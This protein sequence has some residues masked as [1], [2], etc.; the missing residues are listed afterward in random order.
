M[1]VGKIVVVTVI[2]VIHCE[3][4]CVHGTSLWWRS[5]CSPLGRT[6]CPLSVIHPLKEVRP[7]G[8]V[9]CGF[10]TCNHNKHIQLD[11][12]NFRSYGKPGISKV[13]NVGCS[14]AVTWASQPGNVER[15]SSKVTRLERVCMEIMPEAM[16]L[17]ISYIT[18]PRSN[19][20]VMV[21]HAAHVKKTWSSASRKINSM[22]NIKWAI[23]TWVCCA[24][25]Y[26]EFNGKAECDRTHL[27]D[28]ES[29]DS[30][31]SRG[32]GE[33]CRQVRVEVTNLFRKSSK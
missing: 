10:S 24:T 14:P 22:C 17:M 8:L 6:G 21:G 18:G 16:S 32:R 30:S 28:I 15:V 27:L 1:S 11:V 20:M 25:I 13:K 4:E 3:E 2:D 23:Q 31:E 5:Q 9:K 26:H 33:V 7:V 19:W 12:I 29:I